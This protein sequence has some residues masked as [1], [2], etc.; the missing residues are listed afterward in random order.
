MKNVL[1]R[2]LYQNLES[3]ADV[4]AIINKVSESPQLDVRITH[5]MGDVDCDTFALCSHVFTPGFNL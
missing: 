5:F 1:W 3:L 4:T 2:S